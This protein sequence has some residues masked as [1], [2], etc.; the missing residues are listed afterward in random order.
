MPVEKGLQEQRIL[1]TA[2]WARLCAAYDQ[3][4]IARKRVARCDADLDCDS[5]LQNR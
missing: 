5:C 3:S 4:F 2:R 1:R